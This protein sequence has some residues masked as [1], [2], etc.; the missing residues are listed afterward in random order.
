MGTLSPHEVGEEKVGYNIEQRLR[1]LQPCQLFS[2][3]PRWDEL[4]IG[5]HCREVHPVCSE[6]ET[7]Q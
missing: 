2:F 7:R 1:Q 5:K 4:A 6:Y 3:L